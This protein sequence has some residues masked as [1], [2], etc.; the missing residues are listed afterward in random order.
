MV[1]DAIR[2]SDAERLAALKRREADI[3]EQITRLVNKAKIEERKRD[4]RRKILVG[5]AAL[6]HAK[7]D[8][9]F[10]RSL[11]QA[12]HVAVTKEADRTVIQDILEEPEQDR[13]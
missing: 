12:L 3:K 13:R 1:D 11:R 4:T 5:G 9:A 8:A 2:K 10:A 6:A 7:H